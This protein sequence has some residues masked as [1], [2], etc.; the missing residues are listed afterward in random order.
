[1]SRVRAKFTSAF[2]DDLIELEFGP[3]PTT[4]RVEAREWVLARIGG[5]R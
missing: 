5:F 4:T 3:L 1:V 2:A